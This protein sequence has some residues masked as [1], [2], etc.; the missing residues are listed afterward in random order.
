MFLNLQ[1]NNIFHLANHPIPKKPLRD[2]S[3]TLLE[4][5]IPSGSVWKNVAEN[6]S[7]RTSYKCSKVRVIHTEKGDPVHHYHCH[8][9]Y[10]TRYYVFVE[11]LEPQSIPTD[12]KLFVLG[13]FL[14]EFKQCVK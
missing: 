4:S 10:F 13:D 7:V 1:K 11:V 14:T 8:G 12:R 5:S 3:E 2:M 9:V 6:T